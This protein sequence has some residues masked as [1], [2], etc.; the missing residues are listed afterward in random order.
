MP[1]KGG[2]GFGAF[3][4]ELLVKQIGLAAKERCRELGRGTLE[5]E[6]LQ[7]REVRVA[8]PQELTAPTEANVVQALTAILRRFIQ[9]GG[10]DS[11]QH[12]QIL[13]I[14]RRVR[15]HVSVLVEIEVHLAHGALHF[16][17][18]IASNQICF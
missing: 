11:P 9:Q 1:G 13:I 2:T 14:Q 5:Q 4:H 16:R 17:L 10:A 15:R 6:F 3:H 7:L 12:L 18:Y 8:M